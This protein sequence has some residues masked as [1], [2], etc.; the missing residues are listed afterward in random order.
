MAYPDLTKPY[1]LYTDASDTCIGSVLMQQHEHNR[2]L[3]EKPVFY[4]SVQLHDAQIG[5]S[6]VVKETYANYK[7]V[8]KLKSCIEI[9]EV[10]VKSDHKPLKKYFTDSI[11]NTKIDGWL[12]PL[13][14]FNLKFM[15]IVGIAN[16]AANFMSRLYSSTDDQQ[17]A[18]ALDSTDVSPIHTVMDI[19]SVHC[20]ATTIN[21]DNHKI[22]QSMATSF[23]SWIKCLVMTVFMILLT[24]WQSFPYTVTIHIFCNT[25]KR[26]ED[27]C[28]F[29]DCETSDV[30]NLTVNLVQ[31]IAVDAGHNTFLNKASDI[32]ISLKTLK[33]DQD[34]ETLKSRKS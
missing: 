22:P 31:S 23:F 20:Q 27:P 16:K 5:W 18:D 10:L 17:N 3:I 11:Q 26:S 4:Y 19:A 25:F 30:D 29:C 13:Q 15:W 32:G 9:C 34:D 8:L 28:A 7:S 2:E 33:Q 24:W 12:L 21:Q 14:E 1:I 6:L